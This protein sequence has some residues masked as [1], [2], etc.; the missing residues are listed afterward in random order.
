MKLTS[1]L[2]LAGA[3]ALASQVRAQTSRLI[4]DV[5]SDDQQTW[6]QRA[7]VQPGQQVIFRIRMQLL[8]PTTDILGFG[9]MTYQPTISN[10][11]PLFDTLPDLSEVIRDFPPYDQHGR[12]S[13]FNSVGQGSS[14][15][16]GQITTFVDPGNILRIAGANCTSITTNLV[17]GVNSAQLTAQLAGTRFVSGTDV[18]V[19]KT[20]ITLGNSGEER[21][22]ILNAPMEGIR[23][24]TATWFRTPNGTNSFVYRMTPNDIV[25]AE[26]HV[27]PTP[28]VLTCLAAIAFRTRQRRSHP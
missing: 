21:T 26:I 9:G 1:L 12:L 16:S 24:P 2:I 13:P 10:W 4:F 3:C 11:R 27:I 23:G 28:G 17:W 25:P 14:S 8:N 7:E 15:A 6:S 19:F 18:T 5:S 20:A 22:L